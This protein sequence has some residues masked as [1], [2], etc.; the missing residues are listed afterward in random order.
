M[1]T[2]AIRLKDYIDQWVRESPDDKIKCLGINSDE[3]KTIKAVTALLFPFY[4]VTKR[5]S[6][7]LKPTIHLA[8]R[9]Y[10]GLFND[11][12]QMRTQ[13]NAASGDWGAMIKT[14]VDAGE[15]KL[16]KYY[17]RTSQPFADYYAI[18]AVLDPTMRRQVYSSDDWTHGETQHYLQL[19]QNYYSTF[20]QSLE[21]VD[22]ARQP[23]PTI[24]IDEE[25]RGLILTI[26]ETNIYRTLNLTLLNQIGLASLGRMNSPNTSMTQYHL[27]TCLFYKRG[28]R[29]STSIQQ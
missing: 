21:G 14:A 29:S 10:N 19:A 12:D 22:L 9:V 13:M 17:S 15:K 4:K 8:W 24:V 11:I 23:V 26:Y 3:W 27:R 25:V 28:S 2:R 6:A 5:V 16:S 7:S 20:Y 18:A 1:V